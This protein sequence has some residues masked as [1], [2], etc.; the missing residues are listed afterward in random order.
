MQG[1]F[2]VSNQVLVPPYRG[3]AI[4]TALAGLVTLTAFA[5]PRSPA[6][7]KGFWL[8]PS[9]G[10]IQVAPCGSKLC[11]TL[12]AFSRKDGSTIDVNNSD[13]KLRNRPLC[14]L[15]LG[16]GF[17]TTDDLRA[18]G[19]QIYDAKTGKTYSAAMSLDGDTLRLRGFVGVKL[20]G[21]TELWKRVSE[22]SARCTTN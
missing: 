13:G 7:L 19:G 5:A 22:P 18:E 21:K 2:M 3:R 16:S 17:A 1:V 8:E 9:G 12:I 14:G 11:A 6:S 20:F 4:L 15:Q 10:I